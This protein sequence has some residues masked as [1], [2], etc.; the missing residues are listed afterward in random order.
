MIVGLLSIQIHLHGVNSLKQKRGIVKSLVER[1]RNKFNASVSEVEA[2]DSHRL[3][4][5]GI[6]VVSNETSFV[7]RQLDTIL[8]FVNTDPRYFTGTV[9][10]EIFYSND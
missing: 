1:L 8:N 10:R 9:T 5:I 4:V 3:A 7:D 2:H 6:S